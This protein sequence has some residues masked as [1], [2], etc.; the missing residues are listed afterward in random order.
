MINKPIS[1]A[2]ASKLALM[3]GYKS[4][5]NDLKIVEQNLSLI[6]I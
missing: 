5:E 3:I 1:K 6:H 4:I 2:N